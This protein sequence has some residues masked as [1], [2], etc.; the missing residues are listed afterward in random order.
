MKNK[1]FLIVGILALV[2]LI[3]A[4]AVLVPM[5]LSGG[6]ETQSAPTKA[7]T[8][9]PSQEGYALYWNVDR[10]EYDGKSDAGM[11]S[12]KSDGDGTFTVRFFKDGQF[13]ELKVANRQVVNA[14]DVLDLMGLV[15]DEEGTV[16]DVIRPDKLPCQR[17]G[18]MFYVQSTGGNLLKLNSSRNMDG[19]EVVLEIGDQTKLYDMTGVEGPV[20][21]EAVPSVLDR[22]IAIADLEGNLT[23]VFTC[24]R[25]EYM[26]TFEA[27]CVHCKQ[28][29]TWNKWV[30]TDEMPV[31]EGHY[32]L[33]KDIKLKSQP[34]QKEDTKICIDLNGVRV[35][36]AKDARCY[37]MFNPGTQLAIMDTSEGQTGVLAPHGVGHQG[38][39]VWV[40]YGQFH[41]Y[42]GTVD[43]SDAKNLVFGTCLAIDANAYAY[44]HGGTIKNGVAACEYV[45]KTNTYRRGL[46]GNVSV[47]GKLV[48]HDGLIEGGHA[49]AMISYDAKGQ[50]VYNRGIGGNI[51]VTNG[52]LEI[53]G[54]T[55]KNGVADGVGGNIYLDGTSDMTMN[56]GVISGGTIKGRGKNGGSVYIG[57]KSVLTMNNGSILGGTSRNE[58]GAVYAGGTFVMKGG[59]IGGGKV[60]NYNTGKEKVDCPSRNVFVVNSR[61]EMYGGRISGGVHAI[62]TSATDNKI[63]T[64]VL[65]GY[66]TIYDEKSNAN[67]TLNTAGGGVKVYAGTLY[68]SAKIGVHATTG[69][70]SQPTKE[71]NTDNF[72]S[73]IPGAQVVYWE[74]K[75][76]LGKVQCLCAQKN[77][78]GACDGTELLWLPHLADNAIPKTSGNYFLTK[79]VTLTGQ[80]SIR[81][82]QTIALD[83]NGFTVEASANG[84]AIALFDEKEAISF[85]L[86]DSVGTGKIR[87][88]GQNMDF[89][90]C[91]V[92]LRTAGQKF[93]LYA[94]TL[95]ASEAST[96]RRGTAIYSNPGTTV[97]IFGGKILGGAAQAWWNEANK[98]VTHGVGGTIY[99]N[100]RFELYGGTVSGGRA[101]SA[102]NPDTG[103]YSGGVGGNLSLGSQASVLLQGGTL[104]GGHADAGG[105]NLYID[106]TT[107]VKL[108]GTHIL[109]GI[110]GN[111][112]RKVSGAGGNIFC[113][114]GFTMTSGKVEGGQALQNA[115][116]GNLQ[117]SSAG[118][119][120]I[121]GGSFAGGQANRGGNICTM[122]TLMLSGATL[123]GGKA[124]NGG[125]L[126]VYGAKGIATLSGGKLADGE[127]T[128]TGGNIY[129]G[130]DGATL[131]LLGGTV[132][133]GKAVNRGGNL[134]MFQKSQVT[135]ENGTIRGGEA[136]E[137]GSIF[138]GAGSLQMTGGTVEGGT[139]PYG[140][141][142]YVD[143]PGTF[144]LA[145]GTVKDG[146]VTRDGAGN[147]H[148]LG[149]LQ[150]SGGTVEGGVRVN[151][152]G[153]ATALS[154]VKRNIFL[155][156]GTLEM[157]GGTVTG[158]IQAYDTA[159]DRTK[160]ILKGN[161]VIRGD[162]SGSNLSLAAGKVLLTLDGFAGD[163]VLS[164]AADTQLALAG[165]KTGL[166]SDQGLVVSQ[167]EGGIWLRSHT[168]CAACPG[169]DGNHE[170]GCTANDV[171]CRTWDGKAIT[172][173]G[174]YCLGGKVT[175]EGQTKIE[176]GLKV[177]LCL[178]GKTFS[179]SVRGFFITGGS[180]LTVMDCTGKGVLEAKGYHND[181]GAVIA[182]DNGTFELRGGTLRQVSDSAV[183][184]TGGGV[185]RVDAN[186]I[187]NIYD[188]RLEGGKVTAV[189][190]NIRC[191]GQVNIYGGTVYG[192]QAVNGGNIG[193]NAG[194]VNMYGG[195]LET[196]KATNGGNVYMA[197]G[198]FFRM[199]EDDNKDVSPQVTGGEMNSSDSGNG[200][201]IYAETGST[202]RIECGQVKNG[203]ALRDSAGN[204]YLKGTM[205]MTGGTV[206]GGRRNNGGSLVK[207]NIF[208]HNGKVTLSGG[209]VDGGL[210][211]YG[212]GGYLKL[213]KNVNV[214]STESGKP[215]V[216]LSAGALITLENLDTG[217]Q[218]MVSNGADTKLCAASTEEARAALVSDRGLKVTM[219]TDGI[220][221]RAADAHVHCL[222]GSKDGKHQ[223]G[224]DGKDVV[225]APWTE[226]NVLPQNGAYYLP[227][228]VTVENGM[229]TV[230]KDGAQNLNLCLNG[231]TVINSTE[232]G[233]ANTNRVMMV[234][235][236]STMTLADCGTTGTIKAASNIVNGGGVL[237]VGGNVT[238]YGGHLDG[239]ALNLT[240]KHG[241][242]ISSS[243]ELKIHGGTFTGGA[244]TGNGGVIN[245]SG[246]LQITG[247]TFHG[248][249]ITGNGGVIYNNGAFEITGG[250]LNGG[251]A[252]RG[253]SIYSLKTMYLKGGTI[254][255]GKATNRGGN[256][257]VEGTLIMSGGTIQNGKIVNVDGAGNLDVRG[258]LELSGGL[259][260]GG[261]RTDANL[262]PVSSSGVKRNIFT[263]NSVVTI[264]GGQ[265]D[266]GVLLYSTGAGSV[267][268]SG[269]A[270]IVS[271]EA[272][273]ES[274]SVSKAAVIGEGFGG[275]Q[276]RI[277]GWAQGTAFA[278]AGTN[279]TLTNEMLGCFSHD[280]GY[281]PAISGSTIV[282]N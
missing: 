73:D 266:G 92:W 38:M 178:H 272:N 81:G 56:G 217:N 192:G 227:A 102:Q 183:T 107:D 224:C 256:V 70:F 94:G 238:I 186:G 28:T 140:G 205:E 64:V 80:Q 145:G 157:S 175:V 74:G 220:Y 115:N 168:H 198:T 251:K 146:R 8:A 229:S 179:S 129:V 260:T 54:G 169:T 78:L 259:I 248:S 154:L 25:S 151:D 50:P 72:T 219:E 35:D 273:R 53:N 208:S 91:L 141:N 29:V 110:S 93:D 104:E 96:R 19:L 228:G 14:I 245:N 234:Y 277:T 30:K 18:W 190:G 164:N 131:K 187:A 156:K 197:S 176:N 282:F 58:A 211:A 11:S 271:N 85:S 153:E 247:G 268:F 149:K 112:S 213:S 207:R 114:G 46:G 52:T 210:M 235:A 155:Y 240:G 170:D 3:T 9:E 209:T 36:G 147:F 265:V 117:I 201:N 127:V 111:V 63:T 123:S 237:Q 226:T 44:M 49:E 257:Y 206:S 65:S 101:L 193:I 79:P 195:K 61:F 233:K 87:T 182:V 97:R 232:S 253:G 250:T 135:V 215:S 39:G 75:L 218:V 32:Q 31:S 21:R 86:T 281:T 95:D 133:N 13:L 130:A 48:I 89:E 67:L 278:T 15:F 242:V 71:H 270:V 276:L 231:Q 189:G 45:E 152:K 252:S 177:T 108:C 188:G 159:A 214:N 12:R 120:T 184:V 40:R 62:D 244:T 280:S 196:G 119:A 142:V 163:V 90:G 98:T 128:G 76:A 88:T 51:Y 47:A 34:M 132:E 105:G 230:G 83:L 17:V 66:A 255:D 137:G 203:L 262:K 246:D 165:K 264:S 148:V 99:A 2:L 37:A 221:L 41:F 6:G 167:E 166:S 69:I 222:C 223:P 57:G 84:R 243:G 113:G 194:Q 118:T 216:S 199:L 150:I 77:H 239:S 191:N 249:T 134:S 174:L 5:L 138:M 124:E 125:N 279:V 236:G 241:A 4:G 7:T 24:D 10:A 181:S 160:V 225:F 55:I 143:A 274:L 23:H 162:Q 43:G 116:G 171:A 158:G 212:T 144:V 139:S 33:Q 136:K 16:V 185:L 261:T 82:A 26:E 59:Y 20:G 173:S 204:I 106:T 202:L 42:G 60:Y 267:T 27:E 269:D 172:E 121:S 161:A 254:Q 258:T 1:K 103:A 68:D 100:G 109:N 126:F 263:A 200:G 275:G 180:T 22:V 122:G